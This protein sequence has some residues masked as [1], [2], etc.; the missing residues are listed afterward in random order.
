MEDEELVDILLATYNTEISYLKKQ[1]DSLL[2]QTYSNLKIYISDDA[3]SDIRIKELLIEYEKKDKRIS[4]FLQEANQGF[5]ANFEFLLKQSNASYIMFCDHDDIWDKDKV[6]ISLQE[7]KRQKVDLVYCDA[8]QID[9]ED[10]VIHSSYLKYKN[11]PILQG[12]EKRIFFARHTILGCTQ[13]ITK[14]IKEKMIPF[15]KS[16]IAHDW[17][18]V[19]LANEGRGIGYIPKTLLG[20]R[21]HSANVYGG[22]TLTKNIQNWKSARRKNTY[23]DYLDYRNHVISTAYESG[24]KMSLDYIQ[25]KENKKQIEKIIQYYEKLKKHPYICFTIFPYFQFLFAKGLKTRFLKEF[26]LFHF[27]ILGYFRF[28]RT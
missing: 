28:K 19:V 24:S 16:V 1:I 6:K 23:Q 11:L 10:N 25:K 21:L 20:Y 9:E 15:K 7:I 8:R 14:E 2:T 22:R 27:P 13:M 12:K 17:L 5:Q 18:S 3:S 4:L 26:I